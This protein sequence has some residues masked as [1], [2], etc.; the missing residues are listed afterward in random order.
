MVKEISKHAGSYLRMFKIVR[1]V[2]TTAE[3]YTV[4]NMSRT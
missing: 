2:Y 3:P 1:Y 4:I